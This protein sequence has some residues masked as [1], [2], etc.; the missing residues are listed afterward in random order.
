MKKL[1]ATIT[2]IVISL[3]SFT[4]P[5]FADSDSGGAKK[6]NILTNCAERAEHGGDGVLCIVELVINV[7]TIGIGVVA[8]IGIV[9]A[10]V[11]YLTAGGN[12]EQTRKAK[13]RI[14]EIVIGLAV[15]AAIYVI[16]YFL[17]P[18]FGNTSTEI[19]P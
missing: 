14:L 3:F 16:L 11:Q 9:I 4:A 19:G 5:V 6:A 12:E 17:L 8:V 10:G 1:I 2:A 15:Y 18:N 7:M 13:R